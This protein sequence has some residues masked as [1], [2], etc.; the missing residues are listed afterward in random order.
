M[1]RIIF[2][3]TLCSLELECLGMT[4]LNEGGCGAELYDDDA[5]TPDD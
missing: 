2:T 1:A 3:V 4:D 5:P